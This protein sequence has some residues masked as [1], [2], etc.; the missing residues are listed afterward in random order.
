MI[1]CYLEPVWYGCCL[2]AVYFSLIFVFLFFTLLLLLFKFFP[3]GYWRILN[4]LP[5]SVVH[6]LNSGFV[7]FVLWMN[8]LLLNS[9]LFVWLL[10]LPSTGFS[11]FQVPNSLPTSVSFPNWA[12]YLCMFFFFGTSCIMSESGFQ[13]IIINAHLGFQHVVQLICLLWSPIYIM[14]FFIII[15]NSCSLAKVFSVFL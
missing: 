13:E 9:L 15:N 5:V 2:I 11:F 7:F 10:S 8:F 12:F 14:R 1:S 3:Y 6:F 4:S